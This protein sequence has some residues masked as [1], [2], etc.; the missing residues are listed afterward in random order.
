MYNLNYLKLIKQSITYRLSAFFLTFLMLFSSVGFSID[1]HY[2]KGGIEKIGF[3]GEA[4]ECDMMKDAKIEV[5]QETEHACCGN[6][7]KKIA[8]CEKKSSD[9]SFKK[10]NCCHNE[11][12]MLQTVEDG[13]TS[14]YLEVSNEDLDFV[15]V[16]IINTFYLFDGENVGES[17]YYYK[18]PLIDYD[19]TILH[20][21]FLI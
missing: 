21:V 15:T 16:F 5:V 3:F 9:E 14:S 2:C 12:Y 7:Q 17:N 18:P 13:T 20:Q 6:K 1:V 10:G 11:N 8:Q 4:D 19:V